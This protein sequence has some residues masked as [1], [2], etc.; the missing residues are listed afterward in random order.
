[1]MGSIDDDLDEVTVDMVICAYMMAA[2]ATASSAAITLLTDT[3]YTA[4]SIHGDYRA[5]KNMDCLNGN[6]ILQRLGLAAHAFPGAR[7]ALC[8]SGVLIAEDVVPEPTAG[9]NKQYSSSSMFFV[10]NYYNTRIMGRERGWSGF[11]VQQLEHKSCICIVLQCAFNSSEQGDCELLRK[12]SCTA[13][14]NI[15]SD[16][17]F[18]LP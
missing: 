10:Y 16:F 3:W 8:K 18:E 2:A 12:S 11:F 14:L 17:V 5:A 9:T 1:M 4:R 13:V 6:K 7:S 15:R